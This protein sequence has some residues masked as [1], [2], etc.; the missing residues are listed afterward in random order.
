[1][2]YIEPWLSDVGE[3]KW[4]IFVLISIKIQIVQWLFNFLLSVFQSSDSSSKQQKQQFFAR[5]NF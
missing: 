4:P 1:M 3:V 5:T 2:W